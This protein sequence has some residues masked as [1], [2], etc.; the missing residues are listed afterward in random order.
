M[1]VLVLVLE[2]RAGLALLT[3]TRLVQGTQ[4]QFWRGVAGNAQGVASASP[5]VLRAP[6]SQVTTAA[7]SG[8]ER[9]A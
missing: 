6:Q 5:L 7:L 9:L 3:G 4:G 2:W 1:L 8:K